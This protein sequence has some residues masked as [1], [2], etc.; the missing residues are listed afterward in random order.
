MELGLQKAR[1][2]VAGGSRGL[3]F[4]CADAFVAEG[5]RVA[6]GGRDTDT[7]REACARLG[8][9][10]CP[11]VGDLHEEHGG[12]RFVRDA[13]GALGGLDVLVINGGGPAAAGVTDAD[14]E[15][16]GQAF[17]RLT[18]RAIEM[19]EEALPS[20]R[21]GKGRRSIIAI[22]SIAAKQPSDA[23]ALSSVARAGLT[24][25]LR[26]LATRLAPEGI[27]VNA[28]APGYH[29]TERL[30]ELGIASAALASTV[31]TNTLGVPGDLGRIVAFLAG[32]ATTFVTGQTLVV[33]GGGIK[34]L[35]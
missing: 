34:S 27:T 35:F 16:F 3:G 24:S 10:A 5:A 28:V 9:G 18:L 21:A 14:A 30:K 31:P 12:R 20:L 32:D 22:T 29:D 19:V 25:Y 15:A 26:L 8:E 1:V 4:A 13:V 23:L 17:E 33:D 2:A 6:I 11:I 7:L